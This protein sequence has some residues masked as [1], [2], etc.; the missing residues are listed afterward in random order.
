M[1]YTEVIAQTLY[2]VQ[3]IHPELNL[4]T[5]YDIDLKL[6]SNIDI[7]LDSTILFWPHDDVT[8]Y[9]IYTYM[10]IYIHIYTHIYVYYMC[11]MCTWHNDSIWS[12]FFAEW[13]QV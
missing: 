13:P 2:N 1:I 7:H 12:V 9:Q 5:I 10:Y 6:G 8:G 3:Y 11:I 4:K